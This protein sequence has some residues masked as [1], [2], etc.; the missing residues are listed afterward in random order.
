MRFSSQ[1]VPAAAIGDRCSDYRILVTVVHALVSAIIALWLFYLSTAGSFA[2]KV[3]LTSRPPASSETINR[4]IK[5]DRLVDLSFNERWRSVAEIKNAL[6]AANRIKKI[7][8]GCEPAFSRLVK[9]G[10]FSARCV[11]GFGPGNRINA[12]A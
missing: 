5:G 8:V 10:N 12:F 9:A 6:N 1:K 2:I 3:D 7:P 11:A 4:P